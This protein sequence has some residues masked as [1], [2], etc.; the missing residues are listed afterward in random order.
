MLLWLTAGF[1]KQ[2]IEMVVQL[3]TDIRAGIQTNQRRPITDEHKLALRGETQQQPGRLE[4]E[5]KEQGQSL[6]GMK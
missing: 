2:V 6:A 1:R 4:I 3:A 5:I